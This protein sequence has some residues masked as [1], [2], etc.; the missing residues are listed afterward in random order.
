MYAVSSLQACHQWAFGLEM[1]VL[2]PVTL[3]APQVALSIA[4]LICLG[5][6]FAVEAARMVLLQ[7]LMQVRCEMTHLRLGGESKALCDK[8]F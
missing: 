3:P 1:A 5:I 4:G 2:F 7:F 6:N 8:T